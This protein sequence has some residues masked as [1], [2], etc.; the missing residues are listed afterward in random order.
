MHM[1]QEPHWHKM[2]WYLY[3]S[4][5]WI[6]NFILTWIWIKLLVTCILVSHRSAMLVRGWMAS[7]NISR[8][9]LLTE[10]SEVIV[11]DGGSGVS[12]CIF[13][14]SYRDISMWLCLNTM[15]KH[16]IESFLSLK[17]SQHSV[18]VNK[19]NTKWKPWIIPNSCDPCVQMGRC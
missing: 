2:A 13:L 14:C 19:E 17:N 3:W 15:V 7:N 5:R 16:I 4:F 11:L 8:N 10:H 12:V 9:W 6:G 18:C 1:P